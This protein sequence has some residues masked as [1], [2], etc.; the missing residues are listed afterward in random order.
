MLSVNVSTA[1][2][3][4]PAKTLPERLCIQHVR[5]LPGHVLK[6]LARLSTPATVD[7]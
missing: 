6:E 7:L 4:H 1:L 3:S 5:G 2:V